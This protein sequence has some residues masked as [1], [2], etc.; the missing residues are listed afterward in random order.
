MPIH[1]KITQDGKLTAWNKNWEGDDQM[2]NAN[3][4][5][6]VAVFEDLGPVAHIAIAPPVPLEWL[7]A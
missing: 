3:L 5:S 7:L 2:Q 1:G 4:E 6:G